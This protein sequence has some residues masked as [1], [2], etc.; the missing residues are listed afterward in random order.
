MD[1]YK[2][3]KLRY[4]FKD[5]NTV[6][7]VMDLLI[8]NVFIVMKAQGGKN[9]KGVDLTIKQIKT[10]LQLNKYIE[11]KLYTPKFQIA[12]TNKYEQLANVNDMQTADKYMKPFF[13]MNHKSI[14]QTGEL[15]RKMFSG[16]ERKEY[17]FDFGIVENGD[18]KGLFNYL[19]MSLMGYPMGNIGWSDSISG[20]YI[21]NVVSNNVSSVFGKASS[22]FKKNP[23]IGV[24]T[25]LASFGTKGAILNNHTVFAIPNI[26]I[27][28]QDFFTSGSADPRFMNIENVAIN[29]FNA[30]FVP[31]KVSLIK[32]TLSN[33]NV[34]LKDSTN[35]FSNVN[36]M[37][38]YM[39]GFISFTEKNITNYEHFRNNF[40]GLNNIKN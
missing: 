21:A 31:E 8:R 16:T 40:H 28:V 25:E 29:G 18:G 9:Q 4:K 19:F 20:K 36:S 33:V 1:N 5:N 32:P 38:R 6:S 7:Q 37:Y 14:G 39:N 26:D 22:I 10:S 3:L 17:R 27:T 11:I 15:T 12:I 24:A 23:A 2:V 30:Q 13:A 34:S 35:N